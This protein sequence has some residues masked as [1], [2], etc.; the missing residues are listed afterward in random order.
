[1]TE[2][3]YIV[4][5][6]GL[7]GSAATRFLSNTNQRV[8]VIGPE[9]PSN[10][11]THDGVFASHY[12]Q[13]RLSRL[14]SRSKLWVDVTR[15]AL[16]DYSH[17]EAMSGILFYEPIGVLLVKADHLQDDYLE[18]PRETV[19][20]ETIAHS[21]Y[22]AGDRSWR[23]KFP[24][25]DFPTTH[26]VL[27]ETDSAGMIDPRAMRRAQ[28]KVAQSQGATLIPQIAI[29]L[30]QADG[31]MHVRTREGEH[32]RARKVLLTT[33]GFTNC[34]DLLP[35]KL[36]LKPKTE[37]VILGEV[38]EADAEQLRTNPTVSYTVDHPRISD[39]Y[40][41]PPARYEN[42]RYYVKMGANSVEDQ[43]PAD[44]G[45]MQQWF[46]SGDSDAILPD[47]R[48]ALCAIMPNANF[49]S[50]ETKRCMITRTA[51]GYPMVDQ[52]S[53]GLFVAV[54]GNGSSAKCAGGWGK[55]AADLLHEGSWP[56]H[57]AREPLK[58]AYR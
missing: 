53:D 24:V 41:T 50:F 45:Q 2:F 9:E 26:W 38:S 21:C 55:L 58:V 30:Q 4:I 52:L 15:I 47:M 3:D 54:G 16:E 18:S 35:R 10:P 43:F 34:Y 29:E 17:L 49:L 32:Y 39:I 44:L 20:K 42:G 13:R 57:I 11:S 28:L 27:H 6:N 5:G 19:I 7:I 56:Q 36:A 33:G 14:A 25:Y 40:L 51:S 37:V 31:W 46:Q 48:Q 22:A 1:M 12:D 23:E 8:A